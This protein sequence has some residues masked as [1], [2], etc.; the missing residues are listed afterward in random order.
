MN[1]QSCIIIML[2]VT[3]GWSVQAQ[4]AAVEAQAN[5]ELSKRIAS[6]EADVARHR[7]ES[8]KAQAEVD[9]LLE[10]LRQMENEKNDKDKKINEL[11]RSVSSCWH[12]CL[13]C[14][15]VSVRPV[16]LLNHLHVFV[17]SNWIAKAFIIVKNHFLSVSVNDVGAFTGAPSCLLSSI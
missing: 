14:S 17:C 12:S 3:P 10:I 16:S 13:K 1:V 8:A 11:E 6:L 9:R 5:S 15:F 7:E 4:N 2:S